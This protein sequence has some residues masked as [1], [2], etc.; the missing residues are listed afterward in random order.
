LKFSVEQPKHVIGLPIFILL[1][2]VSLFAFTRYYLDSKETERRTALADAVSEQVVNG[3]EV[4]SADRKR[5]LSE[6]TRTWPSRHP[7]PKDWFHTRAASMKN[8]LP[9]IFDVWWVTSDM[10]IQWSILA[11]QR[12]KVLGLPLVDFDF[13][14]AKLAHEGLGTSFILDKEPKS[15]F[16]IRIDKNNPELGYVVAEFDLSSTLTVLV[17]ELISSQF[18]VM[19]K[20][21]LS[22]LIQYGEFVE[23]YPAVSRE[24]DFADRT[25]VITL[26][27]AD[28]SIRMGEIVFYVGS[29]MSALLCF[30]LYWQLKSAVSL[31]KSQQLYKAAGEA[32]LDSMF[33]YEAIEN[34][35]SVIVDFKLTD[36]NKVASEKF[37]F[38]LRTPKSYLLSNQ[39]KLMAMETHFT[40][41]LQVAVTGKAFEFQWQNMTSVSAAQWLK[42]QVVKASNGLAVTARDIT[43]RYQNQQRLIQSEEKFRRLVDGLNGHFIYSV[44]ANGDLSYLSSGVEDILGYSA[45]DFKVNHKHYVEER[46]AKELEFDKIKYLKHKPASYQITYRSSKKTL[47]TISYSDSPV[48]DEQGEL[49]AIEG[50]AR[51][52]TKD[53]E[54]QQKVFFQANHDQLTGLFNRYAFERVLQETIDQISRDGT[55]STLCY[56]DMDKFKLVNDTCGHQ[57][58][59]QLLRNIATILS[60]TLSDN[61][62]L[63]RVGG[64]EFCMILQGVDAQQAIP[65]LEQLLKSVAAF[66]F[67]WDEK[68]FHIGA[69]IGVVEIDHQRMNSVD[70]VKDADNACYTAKS[71][72]RNQYYIYNSDDLDVD[73]KNRELELLSQIQKAL[74]ENYFELYFQV[75]KSLDDSNSKIRYEILLRMLGEDNTLISPVIFIPIAER[76]GLMPRI[77]QWVFEN[78]LSLLEKHPE[79]L[80]ELEKCAINLSGASLN[81]PSTLRA[82]LSRLTSTS[83]PVDK[84]CFEITETSA[85]TNLVNA[86][87]TIDEIRHVGC[88]FALDDFGAGM[89]SFTYLKNMDVD[90]IKIDGAFVKDMKNDKSDRATVKAIHDIASSMGKQTIAEFVGDQATENLLKDIGVNYAQGFAIAKPENFAQFLKT[91]KSVA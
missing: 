91:Y 58:G 73:Y 83:V 84:L 46:S 89:S 78:T 48:Y 59:D 51:D 68:V 16:A 29:V 86:G 64:D 65:R 62:L 63:S 33:V 34:T 72:G 15:F 35:S 74:D 19:I 54:M 85:V 38:N 11:E 9:G 2:L 87:K 82:I 47:K 36:L 1:S 52:V 76:Y 8:V 71:N 88:Q 79:H 4:F 31:S 17:G 26:Q 69:S 66:R 23:Q 3:L 77:D 42:I 67:S 80:D 70:L 40:D 43:V 13:D 14:T 18:S 25:W 50:I 49:I 27:T 41:Y 20:D 22:E 60:Q 81:S 57:A 12:N 90:Y 53:L 30:F 37:D 6:L 61:D 55:V 45:E 44:D 75:I 21:G 39:M 24:I 56:I 32:A 10:H 7:N 5:S 28:K